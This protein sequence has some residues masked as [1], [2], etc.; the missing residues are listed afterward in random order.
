MAYRI[1]LFVV[2]GAW[3]INAAAGANFANKWFFTGFHITDIIATKGDV[4]P[5]EL[6]ENLTA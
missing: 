5:C 3:L 2:F 6:L 1:A 4:K